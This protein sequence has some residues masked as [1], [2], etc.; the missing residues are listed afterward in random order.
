MKNCKFCNAEIP[1]NK[2]YCGMKC[3]GL[4]LRKTMVKNNC[5]TCGKEIF[6]APSIN[7]KYCNIACNL[8]SRKKIIYPDT[9]TQEFVK[10]LFHY[11]DGSL[12]WRVSPISKIQIGSKV[13]TLHKS[14]GRYTMSINGKFYLVARV[15]F[16]YHYG[17]FPALVDHIDC[18]QTNDKIENLRACDATQNQHNRSKA[19]VSRFK[20]KYKGV[21]LRITPTNKIWKVTITSSKVRHFGG[22]FEDEED[23]AL[24][25]NRLAVKH[26]GEFARLNI[27]KGSLV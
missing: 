11:K 25:Y 22:Y 8:L 3:M 18:D 2:I 20:S 23:A 7:Q 26:H 21:A 12:Y 27:I 1:I 13:G 6:S 19:N 5:L 16:F 14:S 4:E 24:Q 10:Y 15:I 9:L 17:Y